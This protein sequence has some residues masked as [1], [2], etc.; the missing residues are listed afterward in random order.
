MMDYYKLQPPLTSCSCNQFFSDHILITVEYYLNGFL[1][2]IDIIYRHMYIRT[3][4]RGPQSLKNSLVNI[5][6]RGLVLVLLLVSYAW[7]Q[8]PR[9]DCGTTFR[10]HFEVQET[11]DR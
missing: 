1:D 10:Q 2:M 7:A 3:V 4:L 6:T 11:R 9:R 5:L 8:R